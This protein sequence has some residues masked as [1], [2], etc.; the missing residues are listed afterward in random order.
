MALVGFAVE[1]ATKSS[2]FGAALGRVA[3]LSEDTILTLFLLHEVQM[4]FERRGAHAPCVI[5]RLLFLFA[6][7]QAP[8]EVQVGTFPP[9]P[10]AA[11]ACS[12]GAVPAAEGQ[13]G[14]GLAPRKQGRQGSRR[15]RCGL[16]CRCCHQ[17][18]GWQQQQR[19][20]RRPGVHQLP[21]R[22]F[23][24]FGLLEVSSNS[25]HERDC[26]IGRELAA[27]LWFLRLVAA[28]LR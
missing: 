19:R 18:A 2:S 13:D 21:L 24:E 8:Q 27:E 25:F 16:C 20:R 10:A 6:A 26:E 23:A 28:R 17:R 14:A 15:R 5:S 3:G 11:A 4:S 9:L 22:L 12:Q 7:V 1:S